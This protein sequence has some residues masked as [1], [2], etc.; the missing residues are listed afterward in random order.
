[1]AAMVPSELEDTDTK[2]HGAHA[3]T[4]GAT[5]WPTGQ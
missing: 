5:G 2:A 3:R 4:A 1:M